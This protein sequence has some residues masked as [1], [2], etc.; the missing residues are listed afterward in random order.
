MKVLKHK[1]RQIKKL[2]V[3]A[4]FPVAV[5]LKCFK[6]CM[7]I[8]ISGT[9][10]YL[11]GK[12]IVSV[13]WHNRLIFFPLMF[14]RRERKKS[15][16]LVSASRDGQYITDLL[17]HF[18]V[19]SIRG[20]TSRKAAAVL[21]EAIKCVKE[22]YNVSFTPDGPRGPKYKMGR[23][24]IYL[25]SMTGALIVPMSVNAS[26]YWE[27]KSWDRF[28]IPKPWARLTVI[29]GKGIA[30]PPDLDDEGIEKWRVIVEKSLMEMT[31]DKK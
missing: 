31:S 27:L 3:W 19:K 12:P 10:H 29:V 1:F 20:S 26:D 4:F 7:R 21:H 2:P 8:Q 28:Q 23:G 18:G 13:T 5:L 22:G 30:I 16:A 24:P 15:V 17:K 14:P 9:E 6:S 25:A 11:T